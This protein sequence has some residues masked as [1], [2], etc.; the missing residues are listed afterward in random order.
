M[1]SENR[2][3]LYELSDHARLDTFPLR[4]GVIPSKF[5][6]LRN[7]I[8]DKTATDDQKPKELRMGNY[9]VIGDAY[10]EKSDSFIGHGR[11]VLSQMKKHV[12]HQTIITAFGAERSLAER[13]V[14]DLIRKLREEGEFDSDFIIDHLH[15]PYSK[16]ILKD[17]ISFF[18]YLVK[19]G[20][21]KKEEELEN[22]RETISKEREIAL[23]LANTASENLE[24]NI[25]NN[26]NNESLR[27]D[28][29]GENIDISPICKLV[30]VKKLHREKSN[31]EVVACTYLYFEEDVPPRKMD[32]IFDKSGSITAKASTLI[33]KRV[34]TSVW[35]PE[36]FKP[37]DWFR[38]IFH[39]P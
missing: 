13:G 30:D 24:K 35:K 28:Y 19:L 37:I 2:T 17:E 38:N 18:K 36:I 16:G 11:F 31:G 1:N 33:G 7:L 34:Y 3:S 5:I 23:D 39:A 15:T 29:R 10:E 8:I 26:I 20:I 25:A 12:L 14:S 27:L 6:V 22:L 4:F 9:H 32:E 21:S